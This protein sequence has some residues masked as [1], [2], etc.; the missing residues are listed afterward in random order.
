[1]TG[2]QTCALPIS[3]RRLG[4]V[5]KN[6]QNSLSEWV[7]QPRIFDLMR[8]KIEVLGL[9]MPVNLLAV[10]RLRVTLLVKKVT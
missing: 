8:G 7:H 10:A 1:M 6:F 4:Q 5:L 3:P 9:D 2:V